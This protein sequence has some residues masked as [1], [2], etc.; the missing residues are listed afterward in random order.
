MIQQLGKIELPANQFLGSASNYVNATTLETSTIETIVKAFEAEKKQLN[1]EISRLR[2]Q[3]SEKEAVIEKIRYTLN[4]AS[5]GYNQV[6][7]ASANNS[8]MNQMQANFEEQLKA[9]N[10]LGDR[11]KGL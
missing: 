3:L 5:Y 9:Y 1:S 7:I 10:A 6:N 2:R 4:P 11:Q 8:L